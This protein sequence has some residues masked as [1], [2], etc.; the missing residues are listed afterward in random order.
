MEEKSGMIGK[1]LKK[2]LHLYVAA[3]RHNFV[4]SIRDGSVDLSNFKK[5]LAQD[6][7]FVRE[8]VPFVASVMIKASKTSD[9]KNDMEAI[10]GG[11]TSLNDEIDWFKQEASK[12]S[13]PLSGT[14]VHKANENY[15][16]FLSS[17]MLPEVEYAVAITAFWA[18]EAV[19]QESF[20]HCLEEDNK[21]SQE[22]Q[23]T[24]KRWGNEKFGHYCRSL[25]NI[26]NRCLEKAPDHVCARAEVAF[27][28][29][30][31]H[32]VEFWNMSHEGVG[33]SIDIV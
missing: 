8:F 13:I 20:A 30:L 18:I 10:L 2:H 1:W 29:V 17:L 26:A 27:Q 3:T 14:I 28:R 33:K 6:Y 23:E 11:L 16:M 4:L 15:C 24:C 32:E 25:Q 5:W 7:I 21:V 22:L 19:Y 31:E 9:D 12:W